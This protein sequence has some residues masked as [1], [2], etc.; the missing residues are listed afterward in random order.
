MWHG[1]DLT[2]ADWMLPV[3][4][5]EATELASALAMP[6]APPPPPRLGGLLARVAQRLETGIGLVLL[7]GLPLGRFDAPGATEGLMHLIGTWLGTPLPQDAAGSLV[8]GQTGGDTTAL[9]APMRFHADPADTVVLLCLR[10]VVAGGSVTLLSAPALHNALLK[11][12]RAALAV[13]H[14]GLPQV[15][16]AGGDPVPVPIFS[17]EGGI[18]V[19]RCD[20]GAIAEAAMTGEHRAALAA[21]ETAAAT[22]GLALTIPLHPGDLLFR[23]PLLVWK[24]A[25]TEDIPGVPDGERRALLR[26][27]LST[28]GARALPDSFRP[29]FGAVAAGTRRGGVAAQGIGMVGG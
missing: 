16:P 23:N 19:S 10:Q 13:L 25:G 22:P 28:P 14:Q 6:D 21:L 26:L 3:G 1:A 2:P 4:A 7:R 15:G 9:G 12:D 24:R 29:V 27:W 17:T 8:V 5:E 11:A 20:H 18:F